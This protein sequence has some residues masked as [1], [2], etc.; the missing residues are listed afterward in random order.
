M[1]PINQ[2]SE[3]ERQSHLLLWYIY[4][5]IHLATHLINTGARDDPEA[6]TNTFWGTGM[7]LQNTSILN[8][9]MWRGKNVM[10]S[11]LMAVRAELF[12][13]K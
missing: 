6:T 7:S 10:G 11:V 1:N 5:Y 9:S 8:S 13:K 2:L 3:T 12:T 4:S